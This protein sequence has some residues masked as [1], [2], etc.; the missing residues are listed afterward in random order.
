MHQQGHLLVD[1]EVTITLMGA[2]NVWS[3]G[4]L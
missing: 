2:T 4:G 1:P 3:K